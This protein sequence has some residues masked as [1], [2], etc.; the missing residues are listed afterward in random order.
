M[1][2]R[3]RTGRS[4]VLGKAHTILWL[5]EDLL[6]VFKPRGHREAEHAHP[7]AQRF[8]ILR[9]VLRIRRSGRTVT[10][11]P[12]SRPLTV[13]AGRAHET[14]ALTDTWLVVESPRAQK[15]TRTTNWPLA[16]GPGGV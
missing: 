13:P 3:K 11:R 12:D 10:L 8:R 16:G 9:G 7:H 2:Q 14:W 6:L 4:V 5:T 15:Q 1:A